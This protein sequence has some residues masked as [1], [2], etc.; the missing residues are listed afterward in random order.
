MNATP[1]GGYA[2]D[3]PAGGEVK[4]PHPAATPPTSPQAGRWSA[5]S[6]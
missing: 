5:A 2:A 6:L 4:R 1:P 3:L